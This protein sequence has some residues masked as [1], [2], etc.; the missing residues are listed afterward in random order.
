MQLKLFVYYLTGFGAHAMHS[1]LL[2]S[3]F[4][5]KQHEMFRQEHEI[6]L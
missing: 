1:D 4:V 2:A 5:K 6:G 3:Q